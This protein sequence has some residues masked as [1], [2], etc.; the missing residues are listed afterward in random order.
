[1]TTVRL[2]LLVPFSWLLATGQFTAAAVTYAVALA[3]DLD[4]W[5]ARRYGWTSR[6]GAVYDPVVDGLFLIVGSVLLL[7]AQRLAI[8]PLALY[9]VSVLFRLIPSLV[10]LRRTRAVQST[11]L[12]KATALSGY[13]AVLLAALGVSRLLSG[14]MLVVAGVVNIVLTVRWLRQGRFVLA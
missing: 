2:A 8:V 7:A 5:V 12:S 14:A 6:F 9:L 4:G 10:H 13:V 1:L 3:T 11:F